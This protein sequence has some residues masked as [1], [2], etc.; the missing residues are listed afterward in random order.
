VRS[1]ENVDEDNVEKWLQFDACE[2]VFQHMTDTEIADAA[3]EE[4]GEEE[5]GED[6]CRR[7][8]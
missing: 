8:N 6:E 5:G 4:K 3:A 1:F 7:T 2:L